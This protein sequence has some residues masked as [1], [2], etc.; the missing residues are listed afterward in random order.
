MWVRAVCR[1][2][3]LAAAARSERG[4]T[5]LEMAILFPLLLVILLA[6]IQTALWYHAKSVALAAAQEGARAAA[7]ET[8]TQNAG[9]T[10]ANEFATRAGSGILLN[11]RATVTRSGTT[12]TTTVTGTVLGLLPGPLTLTVTQS[13]TLPVERVTR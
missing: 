6:S 9:G 11:P 8:G 10:A 13:A 3:R 2:R 4:S 12:A 7:S 5:S 1:R